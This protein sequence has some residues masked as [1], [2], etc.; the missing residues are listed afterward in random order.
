MT[1]FDRDADAHHLD[2]LCAPLSTEL[3]AKTRDGLLHFAD[4]VATWGA[5][6][7]LVAARSPEALLEILC[8]DAFILAEGVPREKTL[9]DVGAGAGAPSLSLALMRP[10]LQLTLLE[11]R[12][13]RVAFMRTAVGALGLSDRVAVREGRIEDLSDERFDVALSRAT[14]EPTEWLQRAAPLADLVAVLLGSAERPDGDVSWEQRY[15]TA[16]GGSRQVLLY[17]IP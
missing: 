6:T 1:P 12:R 4:L 16:K 2:A 15:Q 9:I 10:D 5:R 3:S 17:R 7:D 14:F 8:L 11:P 13:K